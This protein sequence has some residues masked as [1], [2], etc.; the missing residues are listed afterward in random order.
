[1]V[2]LCGKL[3][4]FTRVQAS[5]ALLLQCAVVLLAT[6]AQ[7]A[8]AAL[9]DGVV[10]GVTDG[11]TVTLLDKTRNQHK[12]RLSGIDAPESHQAFGQRSRQY[13]ASIVF[14][15]RVAVE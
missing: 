15:K 1:M 7:S 12:V 4:W 3:K 6:C 5:I 2:T 9:P 11:D 14:Q 10:V 13:L 8:I